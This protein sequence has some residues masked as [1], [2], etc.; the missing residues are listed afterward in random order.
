MKFPS[1]NKVN[2]RLL[3]GGSMEH[4]AVMPRGAVARAKEIGVDSMH[5][6]VRLRAAAMGFVV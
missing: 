1:K 3:Y 2:Q 6:T 5:E 4:R